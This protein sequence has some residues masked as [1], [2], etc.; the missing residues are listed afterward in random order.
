[1]AH[2]SRRTILFLLG[3]CILMSLLLRYPLV[4]HE[5]YQTDS[6]FIHYLSQTIA[7]DGRAA[8]LIH[9]LSYLGYF[10]FSYPS[11]IP[12]VIAELSAMTGISVEV[13]ILTFNMITGLLFCLSVFALA[14]EFVSRPSVVILVTFLSIL[15]ARFV[16][17]SYWDGSARAPLVAL[18]TLFLFILFRMFS[19]RRRELVV[20]GGVVAF[21]CFATHHMAVLVVLF[22]LAYVMT[23][24]HTQYLIPRAISKK[25]RMSVAYYVTL[26]VALAAFSWGMFDVLSSQMVR[27]FQE[28]SIFSIDMTYLSIL[29]NMAIVYTN[30]IGFIMVLAVAGIAFMFKGHRMSTKNLFPLAVLIAFVPLLGNPLYISMVI[31]PYV[32]ILGARFLSCL[33]AKIGTRASSLV[34]VLLLASSIALP[35]WSVNRWNG[36]EFMSGDTVVVDAQTFNDAQYYRAV[37]GDAYAI[38][39]VK[40]LDLRI[41]ALSEARFLSSGVPVLVNGDLDASEVR[42]GISWSSDSFPRNVYRWFTYSEP[43]NVD[44]SVR[45]LMLYGVGY[46]MGPTASADTKEYFGSHRSMVV[47]IDNEWPASVVSMYSV[48]NGQ[49]PTELRLAEWQSYSDSGSEAIHLESYAFYSSSTSTSYIVRLPAY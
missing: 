22:G 25:R 46:L 29:V 12:F 10:P 43:F 21:G 11:G 17:T 16:D 23:V 26:T 36:L 13:S 35:A 27:G 2:F 24:V 44:Q 30:Q 7:T 20:A 15:G 39:N 9:P 1:M 28:T 31:A 48:Q 37:A 49:F 32:A 3:V 18:M 4:E 8:W 41:A 33:P 5:R 45:G 14:R 19:S 6:Y 47:V 40:P 34:L 42:D 38:S